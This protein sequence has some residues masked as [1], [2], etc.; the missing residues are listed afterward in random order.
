MHYY[1]T[2]LS[3]QVGRSYSIWDSNKEKGDAGIPYRGLISLRWSIINA[4]YSIIPR[5]PFPNIVYIVDEL[6]TSTSLVE[7]TPLGDQQSALDLSP[8]NS[9]QLQE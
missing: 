7:P 9:I 5:L 1:I 4:A 6:S 2:S 3:L 8:A